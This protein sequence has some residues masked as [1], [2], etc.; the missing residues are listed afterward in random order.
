MMD[1]EH[2]Q[3]AYINIGDYIS[4]PTKDGSYGQV[5]LV[6]NIRTTKN[7]RQT[8]DIKYRS[9]RSFSVYWDSV[10]HVRMAK[11][12]WATAMENNITKLQFMISK[13]FVDTGNRDKM[14]VYQEIANEK[15]NEKKKAPLRRTQSATFK[16]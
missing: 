3:F 2:A 8:W 9:G 1:I 13:L 6:E 7:G 16:K 11:P 15:F 4:V 12:I 10:T 14:L 5:V